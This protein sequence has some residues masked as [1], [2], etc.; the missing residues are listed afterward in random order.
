MFGKIKHLIFVLLVIIASSNSPAYALQTIQ[1]GEYSISFKGGDFDKS[2]MKGNL[3][4]VT[5]Y[6]H[7]KKVASAKSVY[8]DH[9][10]KNANFDVGDGITEAKIKLSFEKLAW[11]IEEGVKINVDKGSLKFSINYNNRRI[12]GGQFSMSS[13]NLNFQGDLPIQ[14]NDQAPK[15]NKIKGNVGTVNINASIYSDSLHLQDM[16]LNDLKL[17]WMTGGFGASLKNMS[18]NDIV[19]GLEK[20]EYNPPKNSQSILKLFGVPVASDINE[21]RIEDFKITFGKGLQNKI[22]VV[23]IP[24]SAINNCWGYS[25]LT[26]EVPSHVCSSSLNNVS[27]NKKAIE[28]LFPEF[29][30]TLSQNGVSNITLDAASKTS[31]ENVK[32]RYDITH[33]SKMKVD[34]FGTLEFKSSVSTNQKLFLE[35]VALEKSLPSMEGSQTIYAK[36]LLNLLDM[37][38]LHEWNV[39]IKDDGLLG[40]AHSYIKNKSPAFSQMSRY[41]LSV[42]AE[43]MITEALQGQPG[44]SDLLNPP[45][46]RFINSAGKISLT[47][48]PQG[49]MSVYERVKLISDFD[50]F[51][52]MFNV[53]LVN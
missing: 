5:F 23:S 3:T 13:K 1:A 26:R 2:I 24:N 50:D 36:E 49:E 53:R 33:M 12:T 11:L 9:N 4:G 6:Q 15:L 7:Q 17:D 47:I 20:F 31:I 21:S 30:E 48:Y 42:E 32:N 16:Q 18:L 29:A 40:I 45:I 14:S 8:F 51:I 44:A 35:M 52:A 25:L 37:T 38:F 10:L 34:N 22:D 28:Q 39:T 43:K 19:V 27:I 46:S 41:Q